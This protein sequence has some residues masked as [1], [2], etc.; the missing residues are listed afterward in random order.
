MSSLPAATKAKAATAGLTPVHGG[1]P[2]P[3][4]IAIW[5]I[6]VRLPPKAVLRCRAV[7]RAW[8]RATSTR[9]FLLAHHAGQPTLP[10]LRGYNICGDGSERGSQDIIPFD[11]HAGVTAA[12]D[13][14]LP[15]VARL[16]NAIFFSK[17][18]LRRPPCHI[19]LQK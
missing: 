17:S 11:H 4:E 15:S 9:D 16:S 8:R 3:D 14:Q 7:C 18:L 10:L 6:L 1:L 19:R 12:A 13:Q 5:E 2:V